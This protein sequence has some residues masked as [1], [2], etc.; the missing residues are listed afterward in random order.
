DLSGLHHYFC[1]AVL[2]SP[3]P[4]LS[5]LCICH[6]LSVHAMAVWCLASVGSADERFHT[7]N[8]EVVLDGPQYF[9]TAFCCSRLGMGVIPRKTFCPDAMWQS[10]TVLFVNP[11]FF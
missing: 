4:V 9:P 11:F 7:T 8:S 5:L 2:C 3:F 1:S 10:P 6:F